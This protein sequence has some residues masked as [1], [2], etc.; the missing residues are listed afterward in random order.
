MRACPGPTRYLGHHSAHAEILCTQR[1]IRWDDGI[2]RKWFVRR[3]LVQDRADFSV[4][5]GVFLDELAF[6]PEYGVVDNPLVIRLQKLLY[7]FFDVVNLLPIAHVFEIVRLICVKAICGVRAHVSD[8]A[9]EFVDLVNVINLGGVL[10]AHLRLHQ[11]GN[12]ENELGRVE[13][14]C[15]E[16][17]DGAN[18]LVA[19]P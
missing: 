6:A 12:T 4:R 3:D 2:L 8:A 15:Q 17:S 19:E 5:R 18:F 7:L 14:H 16:L 11:S 9:K 1:W 10:T 13:G